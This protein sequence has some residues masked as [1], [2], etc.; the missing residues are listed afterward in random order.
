MLEIKNTGS[1]TKSE[2]YP[3]GDDSRDDRLFVK[4]LEKGFKVLEA[5]TAGQSELGLTEI[6]KL[7]G[8]SKSAAQRFTHTLHQLGYLKKNPRSRRYSVSYTVL[9]PAFA[10]LSSSRLVEAATP[11]VAELRRQFGSRV[12]FVYHDD[13]ELMYLIAL[14]SNRTV[15]AT[16]HPG[17]RIP[18]YCTSSG[19]CI[20]AFMP[21]DQAW[22]ILSRSN[23]VK[24]TENT[25]I[26]PKKIMEEVAVVRSQ[27]YAMIKNELNQGE[28]NTSAPVFDST[29]KPIGAIGAISRIQEWSNDRIMSELV[30]A[31]TDAAQ[32]L[33]R[34]TNLTRSSRM[35]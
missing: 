2:D 22:D 25:I 12:G 23:L 10:F 34:N 35:I 15:H 13:T 17:Y 14:Q 7:T 4:S 1:E 24:R 29:G 6:I 5:F 21:E 11:L 30:P 8:Y 18:V 32:A 19:R 20:L 27:G 31:I 16:A 26:D 9:G 28:F 33:S 3:H